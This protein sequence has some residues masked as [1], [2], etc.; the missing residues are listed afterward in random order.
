MENLSI[1]EKKV[2]DAVSRPIVDQ[3]SRTIQVGCAEV[4]G[5]TASGIHQV[6]CQVTNG[7]N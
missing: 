5:N 2:R 6:S 7:Q 4:R 1:I 3:I